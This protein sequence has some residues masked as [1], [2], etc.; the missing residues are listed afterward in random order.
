MLATGWDRAQ[1]GR[2]PA[3]VVRQLCW[4]L[5]AA[6]TWSPE[7][8]AVARGPVPPI[9][10]TPARDRRAAA[11]AALLALQQVLFPDGD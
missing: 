9:T 10:D 7:L 8:V 1:L 4:R 2:Q 11:G 3:R 6:R 5:F